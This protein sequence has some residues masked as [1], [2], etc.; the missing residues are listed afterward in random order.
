MENLR[1]PVKL[2]YVL[3]LFFISV[4][5]H[6]KQTLSNIANVMKRINLKKYINTC[7]TSIYVNGGI[8][9]SAAFAQVLND[10]F[11]KLHLVKKKNKSR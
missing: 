3:F 2:L 7:T 11:M 5:F 9:T 1:R 6:Q 10:D 8:A 4:F